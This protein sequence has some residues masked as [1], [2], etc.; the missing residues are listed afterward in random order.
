MHRLPL[1]V[2]VLASA[3]FSLALAQ[4]AQQKP[5][6]GQSPPEAS[7]RKNPVPVTPEGLAAA[8]KFYGYECAMCHGEDGSGKSELGDSMGLT[9]KDWRDPASLA[10]MSDAELYDIL[11]HGKGKMAA[12][13]DRTPEKMRWNL[14]N[15]IRSMA[16]K[17]GSAP[18]PQ[19]QN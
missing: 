8:K 10:N 4:D 6:D 3:S 19:T 7:A 17:N 12:Q 15:Y 14:I 13:G 2:A 11:T 16:R 1:I 5:Q 9:M 18:Q